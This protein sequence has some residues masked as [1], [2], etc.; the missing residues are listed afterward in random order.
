MLNLS[1]GVTRRYWL[2]HKLGEGGMGEVYAAL[3]RLTGTPV[4]LKRVLYTPQQLQFNTHF[5]STR[6][7][8]LRRALAD[9]FRVLASLRHPH[10]ISVLDYGFDEE[11]YPYYTMTLLDSPHDLLTT[12][13]N[14]TFA[15]R[16]T[17]FAQMLQA[18]AYLHRHGI[19]HRD[20]KPGNVMVDNQNAVKLVDFGLATQDTG[21]GS[22]GT[23][24]YMA[25]EILQHG[26]ASLQ[27][28]LYAAGLLAYKMFTGGYPF[29]AVSVTELLDFMLHRMPDMQAV[30]EALQPIIT[31]LLMKDP[32]DR[33]PD[34][35]TVLADL[36][37]ADNTLTIDDAAV[38]DSFLQA[39]RFVGREHELS[40]LTQALDRMISVQTPLDG[41]LLMGSAYLIGGES[42]AGKSRLLEELRTHALLNGALV[43]RGQGVTGSGMP[44]ELWRD[45]VRRLLLEH[46]ISDLEAGILCEIVPDIATLLEREI[47]TV[48]PLGAISSQSRLV[49]TIIG[50]FQRQTQPMLLL[51][52]DLQ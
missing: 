14:F 6:A 21:D 49:D 25:P 50:L 52:E 3:D 1:A 42:G 24:A 46:D 33:Y 36:A 4:A 30:P 28:D 18:L 15:Q 13:K 35:E 45:I 22:S 9:E 5:T 20:L 43:L 16:M 44:F 26:S 23:L 34:A 7:A 12:A 11:Q 38:R 8:D 40:V 41:A 31:R 47:P 32:H 39:A 51:L 2:Q 17:A 48:A 29:N 10:I 19:L 27:S 37:T